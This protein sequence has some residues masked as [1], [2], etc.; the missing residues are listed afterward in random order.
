MFG[1]GFIVLCGAWS[2]VVR[3]FLACC[4]GLLESLPEF[5]DPLR[6]RLDVLC[7][8]TRRVYSV[9]CENNCVLLML[10]LLLLLLLMTPLCTVALFVLTVVVY[11]S[12]AYRFGVAIQSRKVTRVRVHTGIYLLL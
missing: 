6:C 10:L 2:T 3:P 1:G 4:I 9:S 7:V 11:S 5:R 12:T 8:I